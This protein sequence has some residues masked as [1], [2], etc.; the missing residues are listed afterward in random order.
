MSRGF[1]RRVES[2]LLNNN[3]SL[4]PSR[5]SN[6]ITGDPGL[7]L[8]DSADY[9]LVIFSY[10]SEPSRTI[11]SYY[12]H[13]LMLTGKDILKS[14][15]ARVLKKSYPFKG[16]LWCMSVIPINKFCVDN[17]IKAGKFVNMI[18]QFPLEKNKCVDK[19]LLENVQGL[20][21]RVRR[22]PITGLISPVFVNS[23]FHNTYKIL[24]ICGINRYCTPLFF[25]ITPM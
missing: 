5:D 12:D 8:L 3:F 18:I 7:R 10:L 21:W 1:V 22:N 9:Q 25:K 14:T 17:V 13:F 19:K 6:L 15:M 16:T 4:T 24:G 20:S 11:S 23:N 2:E